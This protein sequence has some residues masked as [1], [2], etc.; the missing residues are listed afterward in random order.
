[1]TAATWV[2]FRILRWALWFAAIAYYWYFW[3]DQENHLDQFGHLLP[4]TEAFMCGLPLGAIFT[5]FHELMMRER[6]GLP[7]PT[8]SRVTNPK[9]W[10]PPRND[11]GA[12][13][14]F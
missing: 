13:L 7:R 6:A 9:Y 2:I 3:A 1:M 5:G 14:R 8:F 10:P 12:Q 11:P 4:T